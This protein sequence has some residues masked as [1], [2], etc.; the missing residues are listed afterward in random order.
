MT[1]HERSKGKMLSGRFATDLTSRRM[2]EIELP[3]FVICALRVRLEAANAEARPSER[4]SLDDLIESELVS[5]ISVRDVL[6]IDQT[7]PGF[8]RAVE[9]WL[10][11]GCE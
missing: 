2:L 7:V 11:D 9:L 6:A 4:C 1:T 10:A 3:E 8:A 5:L